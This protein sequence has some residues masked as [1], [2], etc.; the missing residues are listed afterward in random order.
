MYSHEIDEY[1]KIRNYLLTAKE[2]IK[3]LQ[4]SPQINHVIYKDDKITM[5]TEDGYKFVLKIKSW[6]NENKE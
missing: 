3:M 4:E 2:Y 6:Y 1:L 5:F